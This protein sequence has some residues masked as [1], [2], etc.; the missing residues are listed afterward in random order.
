MAFTDIHIPQ[1]HID[2]WLLLLAYIRA[3][4]TEES[5]FHRLF[6]QILQDSA[7]SFYA[8]A[9]KLKMQFDFTVIQT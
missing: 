7:H 2:D 5:D 3:R 1:T 9:H 4:R 8:Q 6:E